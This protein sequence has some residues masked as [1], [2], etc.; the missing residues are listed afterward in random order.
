MEGNVGYSFSTA[1]LIRRKMAASPSSENLKCL[2]VDDEPLARRE[3][4]QLLSMY[5]GVTVCGEAASVAEALSLTEAQKPDLVF[6][7]IQMPGESGFDYV[8]RVQSGPPRIVFVTA[9]DQYAVK[10]FECNAMDYLLKP[11]KPERLAESLRRARD[12]KSVPIPPS[13]SDDVVFIKGTTTGRFASWSGISHILA[14]GNYSQ[15]HFAD[16]TNLNVLRTLKD[17]LAQAPADTLLQI[18]RTALINPLHIREIA[19][20]ATPSRKQVLM[21]SGAALPVGRSHIAILRSLVR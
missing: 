5:P 11:V 10:G 1:K 9:Y 4:M 17:W 20:A 18:H 6:L 19:A 21:Q 14:E 7:D 8:A 2:I 3:M 13:I 15:V 16:G 12:K